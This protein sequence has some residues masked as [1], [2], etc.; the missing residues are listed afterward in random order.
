MRV[1]APPLEWPTRKVGSDG[2]AVR[3]VRRSELMSARICDV[4]P[5]SP[6]E[7]SDGEVRP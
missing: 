1:I 6:Y 5:E 3:M 2:F 7:A 4:G